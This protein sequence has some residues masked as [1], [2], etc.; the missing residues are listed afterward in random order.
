MKNLILIVTL[1]IIGAPE[2][3]HA[4]TPVSSEMANQYF[5]NCKMNK[6]PRFATEV[7][8]MFCAC[9]AVKMTE[10]FTVEDMQTMGQQ[11]QAGRDAT[12]KLIINIYAPCIQYPARAYHYSTCVQNPKTKMLGKNVDGLCGCAADNVATHLQ[13][14]AQN[15]FRQILAQNPNVGDPMQALYDSPSFQQ[16]AQSK[17]MSCVGR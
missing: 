1:L 3:G 15:L 9:T 10:G 2:M 13:Q 17:L 4:Q 16:V 8:E 5:A 6:D 12:N 7:Q 11:N 14:N